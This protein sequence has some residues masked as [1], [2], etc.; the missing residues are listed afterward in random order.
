MEWIMALVKANTGEDGKLDTEKFGAD[1]KAKAADYV[2]PKAQYNTQTEALK[3]S[4]AKVK[5]AEGAMEKI[6]TDNKD[7]GD[8]QKQIGDYK[9]QKEAAE[10]QLRDYKRTSAVEKA[11]FDAG[12]T[13]VSYMRYKL[14]G[15][16]YDDDG[17]PKDLD[18]KIKALK[19]GNAGFFKSE[20]GDGGS[21]D[22]GGS[23]SYKPLDNGLDKGKPLDADGNSAAIAA[24]FGNIDE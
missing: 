2:V 18:L 24:A 13:D 21:K 15:L 8:L 23:G 3:A 16:D 6:K 19:E 20:D 1:L 11:L 7:I 4:E 17:S 9:S 14:G 5:A 12:A 10:G 22:G